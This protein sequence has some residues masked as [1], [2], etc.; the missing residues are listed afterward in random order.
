MVEPYV[1]GDKTET[2]KYSLFLVL[3]N[4]VTSCVVAILGLVVSKWVCSRC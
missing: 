3:C 2:F 4:R 1:N